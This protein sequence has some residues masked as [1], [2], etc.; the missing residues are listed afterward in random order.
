MALQDNIQK[1]E[2]INGSIKNVR[3]HDP[4]LPPMAFGGPAPIA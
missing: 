4:I 3:G 2:S 1:Y